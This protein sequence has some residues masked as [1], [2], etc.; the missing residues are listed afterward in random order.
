MTT[1]ATSVADT[2]PHY[3]VAY[4]AQA[5]AGAHAL[6]RLRARGWDAFL[7]L[8][9]P[10]ARRGNEPWKYT[11]AAPIAREAFAFGH[12]LCA[13]DVGLTLADVR[14]IAPWH[15]DWRT[16]V[17]VDGVFAPALSDGITVTQSGGLTIAPLADALGAGDSLLGSL[18]AP[19]DDGFTALN[20]AFV[21][22]GAVI[23]VPAGAD[24]GVV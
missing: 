7:K 23:S 13:E 2:Y 12:E 24:A 10:T 20:A 16:L 18:A 22:D 1:V 17:M 11:N 15:G 5:D 6:R 3:A 4:A 8:G 19:E 21:R 9:L 14:A